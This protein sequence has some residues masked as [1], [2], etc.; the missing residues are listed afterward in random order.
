MKIKKIVLGLSIV[1]PLFAGDLMVE[2]M[3]SVVDEVSELRKRYESSVEE[4]AQCLQQVKEQN[5]LLSQK[6]LRPSVDKEEIKA[7]QFENSR[8]KQAHAIAKEEAIRLK[9][10]ESEVVKLSRENKRLNTSAQILVDKNQSLLEQL[11]KL[12]RSKNEPSDIAL[13][14]KENQSLE[15]RLS[16]SQKRVKILEKTNA[17][18]KLETSKSPSNT[19]ELK[20][21]L[22]LKT[23]NKELSETLKKCKNSATKYVQKVKSSKGVCLDDNPFPKLLKKE[24]TKT[25]QVSKKKVVLTKKEPQTSAVYRIKGESAIYDKPQGSTIEIWEDTRSF[26]SNISHNNW[27][28]ITGFFVNKKWRKAKLEMWVEKEN[29]LKR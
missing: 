29:T 28:K 9:E 23:K 24:N 3:Q 18:L 13:L 22:T 10:R 4:N 14:N 1:F 11:N 27:V 25:V 15:T 2:R 16:S 12:K 7:L 20:Q 8:L 19:N 5:K 21:T 6:G 26:T 17:I